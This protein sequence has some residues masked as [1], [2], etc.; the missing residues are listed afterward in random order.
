MGISWHS[1]LH[2]CRS[3]SAALVTLTGQHVST[4]SLIAPDTK[5]S[6]G[7]SNASNSNIQGWWS[8]LQCPIPANDLQNISCPPPCMWERIRGSPIW[9]RAVSK[10]GLNESNISLFGQTIPKF[11]VGEVL[12]IRSLD[13]TKVHNYNFQGSACR[14][15]SGMGVKYGVPADDY[16]SH[17]NLYRSRRRWAIQFAKERFGP[18]DF[19]FITDD[20]LCDASDLPMGEFDKSS[21]R[22][23]SNAYYGS[24]AASKFTLCPGGDSPWSMRVYE[25]ILAGSIPV[26]QNISEDWHAAFNPRREALGKTPRLLALQCVY[27]V[28]EFATLD[29]LTFDLRVV[30][31]N[32]ERFIKYQTFI[33]GDNVPPGCDSLPA[34]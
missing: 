15:T 11:E 6:N 5:A 29:N 7:T 23:R 17:P 31:R 27:D 14:N 16:S 24:M 10:A 2:T 13:H 26:I 1:L 22:R 9:S 34:H 28:Y 30:E 25:A 19:L 3:L 20:K 4:A 18:D 33:E 32:L 21:Q 8:E 12:K